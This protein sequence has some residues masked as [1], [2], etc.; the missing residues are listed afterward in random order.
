MRKSLFWLA[1]A[2]SSSL[3]V[4][5][6]ATTP[7][8]VAAAAL[9]AA[10]VFDGH[11]DVPEQLRNRR[12]NV[13]AGFDFNDTT[14]E[15]G[16]DKWSDK[17]STKSDPMQTDLP[18]LRAGKVAAQFWSVFV[19]AD[20][21]E[22]QAVQATLEQIDVMKRLIARHPADL[23]FC[24]DSACVEAAM[25]AGKFKAE[26]YGHYSMMK[27][28]GSELSP[29][30]SFEGKVPKAVVDKVRARTGEILAGTYAV[31]V[32]DSQPKGSAK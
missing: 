8:E 10:P 20:L 1:L 23:Q 27:V 29:I 17:P 25:K 22:P 6:L 11:N 28:K 16:E 7:E 26:D 4:P 30:G 5:A 21:S 3:A 12:K 19:P 32:D 18:R 9:K 31:K 24:T 15:L 14:H 13:L 2:A